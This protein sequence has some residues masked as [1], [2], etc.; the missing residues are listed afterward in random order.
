[1]A[2]IIGDLT[3]LLTD[4][5]DEQVR[6]TLMTLGFQDRSV[7]SLL[8]LIGLQDQIRNYE[9]ALRQ[10]GGTTEEVADKQ[11][12]SAA[13]KFKL[14][15]DNINLTAIEL[16]GALAPALFQVMEQAMP[17]IQATAK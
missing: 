4:M 16:G 2:D 15:R 14:L 13:A 7:A 12:E 9:T 17:F 6:T 1:M 3:G 10:A 8:T 5:S 11:L